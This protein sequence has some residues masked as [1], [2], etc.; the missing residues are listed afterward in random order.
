[1]KQ[2]GAHRVFFAW[3]Y[4]GQYIFVVPDLQLVMV[5]SSVADA[6]TRDG[7]HLGAIHEILDRYVIPAAERGTAN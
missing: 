6:A 3:G 7:S 1:M 2:S 4:G 5:T